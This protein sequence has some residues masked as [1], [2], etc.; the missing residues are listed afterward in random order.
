MKILKNRWFA[1]LVVLVMIAAAVGIGQAKKPGP[2][3]SPDELFFVYDD[4]GVLSADTIRQLS[5]RNRQLY[6]SMDVVIACVTTNYGR[7]DLYGYA[8]DYGDRI[9]LGQYDF[10]VVLDVS[11]DNY[12]LVQGP[13]LAGL[14]T[15]DD[16]T[17]YA[18]TYMERPFSKGNYGEALL[19]LT[20]AL[21]YWYQDHYIV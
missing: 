17:D 12:W 4:A 21:Q 13:G 16:C 9:G 5:Q 19:N 6:A 18:Y 2:P 14:F 11:G 1:W 10:I 8:M 20:E 15:D 7:D 3:V